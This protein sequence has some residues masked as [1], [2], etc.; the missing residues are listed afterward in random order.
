MPLVA[1]F[2]NPMISKPLLSA[3]SSLLDAS[4]A[5]E[6]D[7]MIQGSSGWD[8]D[9][10][11]MGCNPTGQKD[12]RVLIYKKSSGHYDITVIKN[13]W[14]PGVTIS[15]CVGWR[16]SGLNVGDVIYSVNGTRVTEAQQATKLVD[17]AGDRLSFAL[18]GFTR[19]LRVPKHADVGITVSNRDH[20]P[21]VEVTGIVRGGA[22]H[23]EG[24]RTS[25]V[26]LSV[27][28]QL[29][30]DHAQ[31]IKIIDTS[32]KQFDVVVA[33]TSWDAGSSAD[34]LTKLDKI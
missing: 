33:F 22:A 10:P 20:G 24:L 21:G 26:I 31:A 13:K 29:I 5:T 11:F 9:R 18:L 7:I 16:E 23:M 14:G 17:D 1:S 4:A 28:D 15:R 30:Q 3:K 19:R 34:D 12:R 25:D 27:N 2:R 6:E 8:D 32:E